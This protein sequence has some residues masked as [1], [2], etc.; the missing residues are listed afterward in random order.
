MIVVRPQ[1]DTYAN[2]QVI[3][4]HM[5]WEFHGGTAD[6]VVVVTIPVSRHEVL[7]APGH[8]DAVLYARGHPDETLEAR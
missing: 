8:P 7:Y 6:P 2:T 4:V 1:T 3:G 5:I